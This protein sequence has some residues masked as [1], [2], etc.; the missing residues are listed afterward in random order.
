[1]QRQVGFDE[2]GRPVIYSSFAQCTA[3][4]NNLDD[5]IDHVAYLIENA[6]KVMKS[7]VIQWVFILDCAGR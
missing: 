6:V 5:V 3:R 1:M 7:G 4:Q 2:L